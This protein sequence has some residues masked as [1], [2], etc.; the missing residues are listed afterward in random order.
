MKGNLY[1][2]KNPGV[3][4]AVC[5]MGLIEMEKIDDCNGWFGLI[6][7]GS[8]N[9][10]ITLNEDSLAYH[11]KEGKAL[12][13]ASCK[14]PVALK[15]TKS[16]KFVNVQFK[17]YGL[18]YFTGIAQTNFPNEILSL[19]D[20][21]SRLEHDELLGRIYDSKSTLDIF[22][23]IEQFLADR[24]KTHLFNDRVNHAVLLMKSNLKISIRELSEELCLSTRRFREI[25][26]ATTGFS[27]SYIRKIE[28]INQSLNKLAFFP[29]KSLTH[30]A[31]EHHY[32]DQSHFIKDFKSIA[33]VTPSQYVKQQAKISDFYNFHIDDLNTFTS[34]MGS[35]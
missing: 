30:V 28:R 32:F 9:L 13:Y 1:K 22:E 12:L 24:I 4:M 15:K 27:P 7:N 31:L 23:T 33:G 17:P 34:N 5:C 10:T 25:F 11:N 2:P 3:A 26:H 21:F 29:G 14:S 16:L 35:Q 18:Y 6:P 20:I 8:S 19:G